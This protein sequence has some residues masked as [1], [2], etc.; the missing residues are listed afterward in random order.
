MVVHHRLVRRH[1]MEKAL[2]GFIREQEVFVEVGHFK[3][4]EVFDYLVFSWLLVK[5]K[6]ETRELKTEQLRS[7]RSR[8]A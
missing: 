7:K 3:S 6:Q 8:E 2:C 5:K 1:F 4:S